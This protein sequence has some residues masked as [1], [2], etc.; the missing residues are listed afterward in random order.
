M[1]YITEK[2]Q[3]RLESLFAA[4]AEGLEIDNEYWICGDD[5]GHSYCYECCEKAVEKLKK[6]NTG[7]NEYYADSGW[8]PSKNNKYKDEAEKE[9][10]LEFY[11]DLH[12][13]C[14][15]ILKK[16]NNSEE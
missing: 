9:T 7:D 3:E 11:N 12:T 13:L 1:N 15:K 5:S 8:R 14:R 2:D 10:D 4:G 16:I 6:E